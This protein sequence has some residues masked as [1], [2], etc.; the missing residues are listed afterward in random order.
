MSLDRYYLLGRSGLRV[1]RL[2]LGT[3]TFGTDGP[4]GAWGSTEEAA[5]AVFDRY[6]DAGGNF[7]DTADLY[8]RGTSET[9]LGKFIAERGAR[10]LRCVKFP[11]ERAGHDKPPRRRS[12]FVEQARQPIKDAVTDRDR[13]LPR[14]RRHIDASGS[15]DGI[16]SLDNL[17]IG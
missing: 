7:L 4:W 13:V 10:Q 1:S 17:V 8:T 9:L 12:C 11:D 6:L 2:S 3:M 15:H 5:R 16:G 14:R